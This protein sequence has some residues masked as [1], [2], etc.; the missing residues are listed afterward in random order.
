MELPPF[1]IVPFPTQLFPFFKLRANANMK[2]L[3]SLPIRFFIVFSIAAVTF[4]SAEAQVET[5]IEEGELLELVDEEVI[6]AY[7]GSF[8]AGINGKSGNSQNIDVNFAVNVTRESD[9]AT[10]IFIAN[11]F[12]ASSNV[13]TTTDRWFSQFRSEINLP[14]PAWSWFNQVGVEIDRFKNYDYRISLHTGLSFKVIDEELRKFKLRFGGGTSSEIGGASGAYN[15]ELQFGADWERKIFE[16]TRIY[17]TADYFP[18]VSDFGDF[19]LNTNAGLD[20]LVDR[21]RNINFRI[22]AQNRF[23][24]TPPVGNQE[25]DLDYGAALVVGF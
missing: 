24:S 2:S 23:D 22:F 1:S 20:V 13:A 21:A 7:T 15:P 12:Y 16:S 4:A 25:S 10:S 3:I 6:P 5:V 11:Y 17:A 18:N 9:F 8:A 14:N 19:R